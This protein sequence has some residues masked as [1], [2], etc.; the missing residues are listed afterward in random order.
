MR[1]CICLA[2]PDLGRFWGGADPPGCLFP[3]GFLFLPLLNL[4][5]LLDIGSLDLVGPVD[6][7]CVRFYRPAMVIIVVAAVVV[8]FTV[9]VLGSGRP[10]N[11]TLP[12]CLPPNGKNKKAWDLIADDERDP[13]NRSHSW[14]IRKSKILMEKSIVDGGNGKKKPLSLERRKLAL[15]GWKEGNNENSNYSKWMILH[16]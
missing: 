10:P 12:T 1:R 14:V 7:S 11:G 5:W 6:L 2:S 16:T 15:K 3:A 13:N 4:T 8:V 9:V